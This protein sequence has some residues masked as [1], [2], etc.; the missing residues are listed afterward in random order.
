MST[1][2]HE[3]FNVIFGNVYIVIVIFNINGQ[4]MQFFES[5]QN[6]ISE[7]SIIG[8]FEVIFLNI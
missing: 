5:S 2:L 4:K 3:A 1:T 8:H 7:K 6:S